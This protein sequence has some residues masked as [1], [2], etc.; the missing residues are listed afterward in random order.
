MSDFIKL[1]NKVRQALKDYGVSKYE[2]ARQAIE[3]EI[4]ELESEYGSW[5]FYGLL[6][7]SGFVVGAIVASVICY[8]A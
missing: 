6:V 4:D 3:G 5:G 1:R 7:G 8:L 2:D